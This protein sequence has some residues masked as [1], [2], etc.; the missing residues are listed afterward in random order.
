[1]GVGAFLALNVAYGFF[2]QLASALGSI[3]G[4]LG[5]NPG[6]SMITSVDQ[7]LDDSVQGHWEIVFLFV[8]VLLLNVIG[9]E[10]WWRGIILPRQ[11]LTYGKWTWV[12][13]GLLWTGFHAFKWWDL[14]GLLP[15]CLIISFISQ[16]TKNNWP[17]Y[18]AHLLFNGLA[19]YVVVVAVLGA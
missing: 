15:V 9:E 11:E 17:A 6:A 5:L 16:R 8:L 7:V 3:L 18:I 13:H 2:S 10:L 12:V 19:L 4:N 14:V 1:M